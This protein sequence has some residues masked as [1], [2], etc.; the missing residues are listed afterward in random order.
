VEKFG[1][2]IARHPGELELV[3]AIMGGFWALQ[4]FRIGMAYAEIRHMTGEAQR[5]ASE[6]LGG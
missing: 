3:I 2:W 1:Q 5:A 6:A 4:M